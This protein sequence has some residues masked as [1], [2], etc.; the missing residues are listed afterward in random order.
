MRT[1]VGV[2]RLRGDAHPTAA[3]THR[4]FEHVAD[5]E[6]TRDLLHIDSLTFIGKARIARDDEEPA[7]PAERGDDSSIMPSTKYSCF[8][9]PLRLAEGSTAIDGLSGNARS[10]VERFA[11]K[12]GGRSR[13]K[14]I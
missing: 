6:F 8:G 4:A 2:D 5:A 7:D 1:A 9:S 12:K 14:S 13:P 10:K 11:Q 3:L